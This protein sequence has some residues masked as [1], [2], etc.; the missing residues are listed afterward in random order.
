MAPI[1]WGLV[2]FFVGMLYGWLAPGRPS[3]ARLFVNGLV[4]GFVLALVFGLLGYL[5]EAPPI[6][7][8]GMLGIV[9]SVLV[10]TL[11]F[12]LGAWLGDLI[13]GA[14]QRGRMQR[15]VY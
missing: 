9:L 7:L 2:S 10:L 4:I 15:R 5:A 6:G 3:K 11:L 14:M 1:P 12:I 13:E 8:E